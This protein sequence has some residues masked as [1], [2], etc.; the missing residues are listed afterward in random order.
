MV[1]PCG[2]KNK[3]I[4]KTYCIW[5]DEGNKSFNK[6]I[7]YSLESENLKFRG[8]PGLERI[9]IGFIF[10]KVI[11]Y[12]FIQPFFYWLNFQIYKKKK[13]IIFTH[14]RVMGG[15][16]TINNYQVSLIFKISM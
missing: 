8:S 10:K 15:A 5:L 9:N 14:A 13:F 12:F 11:K 2:V 7:R 6:E 3:N 4:E 16:R 1:K